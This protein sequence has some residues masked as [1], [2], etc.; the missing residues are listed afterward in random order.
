[1]DNLLK[2]NTGSVTAPAGC[3]KTHLIAQSVASHTGKKPILVLTHTNAGVAALRKR[4]EAFGIASRSYR[5]VTLDGWAMRLVA[6]FPQRSGVTSDILQ[7]QNRNRDYPAIKAG[8]LRLLTAGHVGSIIKATYACAIIDEYQDCTMEQHQIAVSL[9]QLMT[10]YVLGDEMQGIFAWAGEPVDWNTQVAVSFPPIGELTIPYRWN[11]ADAHDLGA[12]LLECRRALI[13][14]QPIDLNNS[15]DA[16]TYVPISGSDDYDRILPAARTPA[17]DGAII[18]CNSRRRERHWNIASRVHGASVVENADLTDLISFARRFSFA[19]ENC[20]NELIDFGG[21]TMTGV[22]AAQLKARLLPLLK[23]TAKKPPNELEKSACDFA[24]NPSP[25]QA[26]T[27]LSDASRQSGVRVYRPDILRNCIRSL[28]KLQNPD[29]FYDVVVSAR[30]Q[31]RVIGRKLRSRSIGSTLLVK[32]LEA[33]LSVL[34]DTDDLS[35][36]DLYVAMTRGAKKLVI[37]S[38]SHILHR[39]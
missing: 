39:P 32:G 21:S 30:E 34:V 1:M 23:E 18:I 27:F 15:P 19:A 5:I 10:T 2:Y 12:W 3:G 4:F 35:A 7:L 6:H 8:C 28:N 22:G 38:K 16:V 33:E 9:S 14:K 13:S 17:T 11:N 36:K 29:D 37:C 20:T 26:A 24:K 25:K 31:S